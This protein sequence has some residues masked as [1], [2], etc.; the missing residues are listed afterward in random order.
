MA[1]GRR[2]AEHDGWE[3]QY[4]GDLLLE[5]VSDQVRLTD[6]ERALIGRRRGAHQRLGYAVQLITLRL[7]GRFVGDPRRAPEPLV[8]SVAEQLG[9]ADVSVLRGYGARAATSAAHR[10]EIVQQCGYREFG[11]ARVRWR[12]VRWLYRRAWEQAEDSGRL[13]E[14]AREWLKE[15][16]ICLPGITVLEREVARVKR[17]VGR[18][19]ERRIE[20][21]L[22][23]EEQERMSGLLERSVGSRM[24]VL[25]Q[26]RRAA[27][28]RSSVS[29]LR[30]LRRVEQVRRF[31]VCKGEG[32]GIPAAQWEALAQRGSVKRA[33]RLGRMGR[34]AGLALLVA[35]GQEL[36][37]EAME[38]ACDRLDAVISELE[39]RAE[40]SSKA[41]REWTRGKLEAAA[42]ELAGVGRRL[43]GNSAGAVG[44][45]ELGEEQRKALGEAIEQVEALSAPAQTSNQGGLLARYRSVRR[46][47]PTLLRVME[48][49]HT[50]EGEAVARALAFLGQIEGQR[51]PDM[52]CAP[53][54]VIGA[55]WRAY[56]EGPDGSVDRRAY[57]MCVLEQVQRGLRSHALF[58]GPSKRWGDLRPAIE[59]SRAAQVAERVVEETNT[60]TAGLPEEVSGLC[61]ELDAGYAR[62]AE[63][64]GA[65]AEV[66]VDRGGPKARLRV[67]RLR[68][69]A[70]PERVREVRQAIGA[71]MPRRGL[72]EVLAEVQARTGFADAFRPVGGGTVRMGDWAERS[73]AVLLGW[74]SNRSLSGLVRSS[75]GRW[76]AGQLGWVAEQ[77]MRAET[78]EAAT[79][80]L[81]AA[82]QQTR[83]ASIWGNGCIAGV[84]GL[85]LVVPIRAVNS[86]P[87][88]GYFGFDDGLTYV[89]MVTDQ[90]AGLGGMTIAGAVRE[91]A[92][93]VG[94]MREYGWEEGPEVVMTDN[95][96]YSDATLGLSWLLGKKVQP[97]LRDVG[98]SRLWRVDREADYGELNAVSHNRVNV[99]LIA[100]EWEGLQGIAEA[101]REQRVPARRVLRAM[102][103]SQERE[104]LA[105]GLRELG[106]L[107][108]TVFL[109]EY[110]AD[111]EKRRE[112]LVQLNR[113]E[114]WHRLAR[115]VFVGQG[116]ELRQRYVVGQE[117][118]LKGLNLVVSAIVLWNTWQM[119]QAIERLGEAGK[120]ISDADLEHVWPTMTA[121]L[122]LGR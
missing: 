27:V 80:V 15:H 68:A 26:L 20:E 113:G 25:A 28:G 18:R 96:G 76:S 7:L 51:R 55:R 87:S 45:A 16:K 54:E 21:Q 35:S 108:K 67:A 74:G 117:N 111:A 47:V 70:V 44:T 22:S 34:A 23:A 112:V 109:L 1:K 105:K 33:W 86:G 95:G 92:E 14:A 48:F 78:L 13:L 46:F 97:R 2:E 75:E 36:L 119:E 42:R 41:Q 73:C 5:D 89:H 17:R 93:V 102:L 114:E 82:Q 122:E 103:A 118:R 90:F 9:M 10:R 31:V 71:L 115:A 39:R 60:V 81:V 32:M 24:T 120:A 11:E 88:M 121:H 116:G 50:R 72:A 52:G 84:D 94:C 57:T 4:P 29:M 37:I 12:F 59:G 30:A 53:R 110:L 3:G 38:A 100:R 19:V 104:G 79:A 98:R 49:E 58:I 69:K 56:V 85:R 65:E 107:V 62:L 64:L 40:Q 61:A 99:E 77:G 66:W 8:Q 63:R 83:L 43:L 106:R 101:I 6:A 91:T